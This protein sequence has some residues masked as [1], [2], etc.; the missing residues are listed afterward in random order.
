MDNLRDGIRRYL[1]IDLKYDPVN[2]NILKTEEQDGYKR[3]LISYMGSEDDD[4]P[5]YLLIPKGDGPFP[6]LIIHHQHNGE[7]HLGKS[8]VC[9]LAGDPMQAFGAHLA[10]KGF[11]VLA[12]DSIC[13][14]DRRKNRSGIIPDE[15]NDWLQHFNEMCYRILKGESLMKKV[16]D[17][18]VIGISLLCYSKL[19]DKNRIGSL[20]HSYGG[21]TA[22]FQMAV[23]E[24]LAFGCSSGAA[25][26]YKTKM[27][28]GTGIEMAEVIPGFIE[29]YDIDDLI[30]CI[31]PRKLLLVSAQ[32]DKYSKDADLIEQQIR[33]K[34]CST[35]TGWLMHK[36]Y[37]GGHPLNR[38]RFD[39]IINWITACTRY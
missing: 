10:K 34:P 31:A 35:D 20:G 2:Y 4:I 28:N 38:E 15:E 29:H 9:G 32:N 39:Y 27:K 19:A 11:L 37:E 22:L 13:F 5:A 14:E 24:R 8:E 36:R 25:C 26:T 33:Q 1:K 12:P 7:R 6:A 21:N 3:L 17:D 30:Q 16:L 23:D 18:A